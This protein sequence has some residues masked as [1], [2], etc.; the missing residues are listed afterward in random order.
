M[1]GRIEVS[2]QRDPPGGTPKS[3]DVRW[4]DI[5]EDDQ[6]GPLD[7]QLL[8]SWIRQESERPGETLF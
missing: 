6:E 1:A 3:K 7:G 5:Y 2:R 8:A 4:I